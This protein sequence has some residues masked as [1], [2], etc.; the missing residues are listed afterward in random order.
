M[1]LGYSSLSMFKS[2]KSIKKIHIKLTNVQKRL[3]E[4]TKTSKETI[5]IE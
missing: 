5:N 4:I 2:Y 3:F 1:N